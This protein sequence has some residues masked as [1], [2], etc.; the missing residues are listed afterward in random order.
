[1]TTSN[2][3]YGAKIEAAVAHAHKNH[4]HYLEGFKELLRI[5]SISTI[6]EHQADVQQAAEWLV[7]EMSR[8]GFKQC[9]AIPSEGQP[10]VYGEWLEAGPDKPTVLVYAHYDVQPIDPLELWESPPFEPTIRDGKIFARGAVDDKCGV[11]LNLKAFESIMV[12]NNGQLPVN[13]KLFFEGEEESGSPSMEPFI[14]THREL[15]QAD[16]LIVSDGGSHP[17]RP[18][19]ITSLRGV[20]D[21]EV[22]VTGPQRDLHSGWFGGVVHNP[23]H[24]VGEMIAALHDK[25]GRV[26]IPGFYDHI[27]PVSAADQ[28]RMDEQSESTSSFQKTQSGVKAFWGPQEWSY[29]ER[30]TAQ[31]TC[32]VNGV[33]G[34]YQGPGGKTVI[35]SKAGFK[36]SFRLV[37][38]QEPDY[39]E[40]KFLSFVKTFEDETTTIEA[41]V[42]SKSRAAQLLSEGPAV[43]AI[44]RAFEAV[45]GQPVQ[46][47]RQGGSV[48][49]MG[50]FQKELNIP[51]TNLGH[52]TGDNRHSPNEFLYHNYFQMGI[53]TAV[54]AFYNLAELMTV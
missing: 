7:A 6:P 17:G 30:S 32:D 43:E 14:Q 47:V 51:M 35:P 20:M 12:T 45:W 37:A 53:D 10:V 44:N 9:R 8:I 18:M 16:L 34:G 3:S 50:M 42:D 26:Q 36:L 40:Q 25:N 29:L 28:V 11:F 49:I 21:A 2:N 48:P 4:D 5:P 39:I 19:N 24:K 46:M 23:I 27:R 22:V 31:P 33:W 1:M 15:L 52:G 54:H 13:I 38:D 41:W